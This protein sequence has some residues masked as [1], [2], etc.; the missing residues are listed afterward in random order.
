[1]SAPNL[2]KESTVKKERRS[3]CCFYSFAAH[4]ANESPNLFDLARGNSSLG[5]ITIM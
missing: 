2:A 1:M 5:E 4:V 3:V